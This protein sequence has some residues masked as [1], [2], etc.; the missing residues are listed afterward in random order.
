MPLGSNPL[1]I[2]NT[3]IESRFAG[4]ISTVHQTGTTLSSADGINVKIHLKDGIPVSAEVYSDDC[5]EYVDIGL[6]M[7]GNTLVGYDGV[8]DICPEVISVLEREGF[9]IDESLSLLLKTPPF[10]HFHPT[11]LES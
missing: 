2:M 1:V 9:R 5:S 11:T 3:I 4:T 6:E 7:E 10:G 8:F